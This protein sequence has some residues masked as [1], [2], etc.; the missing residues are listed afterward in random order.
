MNII[1]YILLFAAGIVVD[2][3]YNRRQQKA[4]ADAYV[5]GYNS[6]KSEEQYYKNGVS[7]GKIQEM[8]RH[9]I[10][11]RQPRHAKANIDESFMDTMH[12]HGHATMQIQ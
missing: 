8:L 5:R 2:A 3:I 10:E 4:E 9:P 12:K 11:E 7:E 6:A 1:T